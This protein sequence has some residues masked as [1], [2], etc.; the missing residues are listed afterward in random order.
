[1]MKKEKQHARNVHLEQFHII[2]HKS[3]VNNVMKDDTK[4]KKDKA[5]VNIVQLEHMPNLEQSNAVN[6]KME[7]Y[8]LIMHQ[9]V[10]DVILDVISIVKKMEENVKIVHLNTVIHI[11]I[12]MNIQLKITWKEEYQLVKNVHL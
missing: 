1:M 8:H 7:H 2:T 10:R 3:N 5:N 6:V 4:M 12:V 11:D 9:I